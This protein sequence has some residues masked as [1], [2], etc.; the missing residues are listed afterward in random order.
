MLNDSGM[1][2]IRRRRL[3]PFTASHAKPAGTDCSLPPARTNGLEPAKPLH[4][5]QRDGASRCSISGNYIFS[6]SVISLWLGDSCPVRRHCL[7]VGARAVVFG[8]GVHRSNADWTGLAADGLL[9]GV[10]GGD[11]GR[12]DGAAVHRPSRR[13]VWSATNAADH[14]RPSGSG[15]LLD[16]RDPATCRAVPGLH[17]DPLSGAGIADADLQLDD[18]SL[19]RT[20]SWVCVGTRRSGRSRSTKC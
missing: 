3:I 12:R 8:R 16:E 5:C 18:R 7:H 20:P 13:S 11:A 4:E 9:A 10:P 15:L 2:F 1:L 19:V 17:H 6:P 14:C